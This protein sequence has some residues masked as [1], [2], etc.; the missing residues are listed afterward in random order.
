MQITRAQLIAV[1]AVSLFYMLGQLAV[2]TKPTVASLFSIAILFGILAVFAGGGIA[3]AFGCLNAV[4][5]A[6]FL[7][8]GIAIKIALFQ[9]SDSN[10]NTPETTAIVM[11]IGFFGLYI[12]TLAQSHL[13][14]PKSVSLDRPYS[15]R[16][17]L[18]LSI[19][20]FVFS[21]F[22]YFA[23]MIPSTQGEGLQTGGWLGIARAAGSLR[24]LSV[25]PPMFYL[26][27][28][29][30][31]R[32]MTHPAILGVVI[33]AALVGIFSTSKQDAMEPFAFYFLIGFLRYGWWDKRLWACVSAAAVYYAV[34]IFPYSQY[35]RHAGGREGTFQQRAEVT[36]DAF[37]RVTSDQDFRSAITG[38]A[39]MNKGQSYFGMSWF[40]PFGRLA[41]VAEA[42]RLI[43]ATEQQQAFTGWETITWGFKLGTP[44]FLY[45]DK[46]VFEAGNYLAH[47]VGEVGPSDTNTQVSYGVMAN[48]YNAFSYIGVLI[49]TPLFFAGFY[50]WFRMFLGEARWEGVPTISALWFLW[51]VATF[52]HSI[53]ESSL[54]GLVAS[55]TTPLVVATLCALAG[56]LCMVI[57]ESQPQS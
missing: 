20:L 41:M 26:W 48:W 2:G 47:I 28:K 57:P 15:D 38:R 50:Y 22:G 30:T 8:I 21:F 55:M 10:L 6:K 36:N 5:I 37:W 11:A 3:S 34:I 23:S 9:P 54:S 35:V 44:S 14:C 39:S 32:W 29:G 18:S 52:Q 45:P 24:S 25:V 43:A 46:P 31:S 53:V 4:L 16:M 33:W 27:R 13:S 17:L 56:L 19:V 7:L 42:D 49:G 51:L 12:G 40:A 1:L